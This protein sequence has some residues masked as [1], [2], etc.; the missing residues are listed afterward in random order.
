MIQPVPVWL[1]GPGLG[2]VKVGK[3]VSLS[4]SKTQA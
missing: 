4:F 1:G 3:A 2:Y